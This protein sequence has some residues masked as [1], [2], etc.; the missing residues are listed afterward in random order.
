MLGIP[1]YPGKKKNQKHTPKVFF[2]DKLE[3]YLKA[4]AL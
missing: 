2:Q 4:S 3:A 1:A